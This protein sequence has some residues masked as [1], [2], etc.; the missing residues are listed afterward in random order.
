MKHASPFSM[1]FIIIIIIN[2]VQLVRLNLEV[3]ENWLYE[4]SSQRTI[5]QVKV[6]Y[7]VNHKNLGRVMGKFCNKC[8]PKFENLYLLFHSKLFFILFSQI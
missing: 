8:K 3:F 7:L 1:F 5:M 2:E 4:I 6:K